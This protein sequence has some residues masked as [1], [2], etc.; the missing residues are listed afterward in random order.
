MGK[1]QIMPTARNM[2]NTLGWKFQTKVK[3]KKLNK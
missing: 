1:Y 2:K 3:V